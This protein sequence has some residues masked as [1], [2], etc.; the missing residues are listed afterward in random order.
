MHQVHT[1]LPTLAILLMILFISAGG[2]DE[3]HEDFTSLSRWESLEFPKIEQHTKYTIVDL[4][5]AKAG[6][7]VLQ[8][9]A[10]ASASGLIFHTSFEV[11]KTPI[12]E[13]RWKIENIIP[14]GDATTKEGDDY[15][16][17]IYIIFPYNPDEVS[18]GTKLKYNAAKLIYGEY[19]PLASLNY[20]WANR[21]HSHSVLPNAFTS[22]AMM[23][24]VE[25][26]TAHVNQWR[27]YRVDI[28]D[29]YR[30]AFGE[31]P[32]ATASL[33]IMSDTDN[34]GSQATAYI[35]YIRVRAEEE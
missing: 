19:P 23:F 5:E 26:G 18:F 16:L 8:A 7:S 10:N 28:R 22:R 1:K 4:Q 14:G 12:V 27:S 29:D 25:A 35:D 17:R 6:P 20:I 13:W 11:S 24:P 33:A 21:Q 9:R 3:I 32:P 15:A 31:E 2:A 30:T 34:T